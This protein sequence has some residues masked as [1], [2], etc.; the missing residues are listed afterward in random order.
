ME[1]AGIAD[2][3]DGMNL[4]DQRL[5][6]RSRRILTALAANCEASINGS[7]DG[8]ADTQAAY[9][10]FRNEQ[11]TPEQILAPHVE[12]T[13]RRVSEQATVLVLQDTT[14]FNFSAHPARDQRCLC[15]PTQLG[16]Y[17]HVNL[18]VTTDR[19]PLGVLSAECFDRAAE[20]F[21]K[22]SPKPRRTPEVIESKESFRWLKGFRLC[23]ELAKRHPETRIVSVADREADIYDI[24]LEAKQMRGSIPNVH[25]V[26]RAH[27]DRSTPERDLSASRRTYHKVR[28]Q[29]QQSPVRT[30]HV[31]D[32]CGTS[33]RSARTATLDVRAITVTVKP[34]NARNDLPPITHN[35]IL[36][37]ECC[38][39]E[40][41]TPVEWLLLTTLPI[42][43]AEGLLRVIDHYAARWTIEVYFRTLKTGCRV[44]QMQLE[45]KSRQLNCL[46]FYNIIAWRILSLTGLNR[47]C[48]HVSC[49]SVFADHEWKPLWRVATKQPL[50]KTPPTLTTFVQLL[51][52]LGGYNNRRQERPPGPQPLWI[53]VRR[54]LDY[55]TAWLTFGP[56]A[57][58][59]CV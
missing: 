23:C 47:T 14:S 54:M 5:N 44:E 11:V 46:A 4:G 41:D 30:R 40:S 9:R 56:D 21:E 37:Q 35:V 42:E 6:R 48:P 10:F 19:L 32:L 57:D 26:L 59:R 43:T 36:V 58:T 1:D 25:Y 17:Q 50:P 12:A 7:M 20:S 2:E 18:A 33:Q 52:Q 8:W 55:S 27:E 15:E 29:V 51:A 39:P 28:D 34:P 24:F 31:V 13:E 53:G 16:F 3:L 49:T 45:T 38:P 22:T